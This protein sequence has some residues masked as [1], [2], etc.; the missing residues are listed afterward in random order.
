MTLSFLSIHPGFVKSYFEF[1]VFASAL[2]KNLAKVNVVNIRD[3]SDDKHS[4]VDAAP[5]GGGDG[6]VL[7]AD[8]LSSALN[9]CPKGTVIYTGPSGKPFTQAD[10]S[11]LSKVYLSGTP[12]NFVCGR[13]GGVDQRFL[14]KYVDETYCV[15]DAVVSGGELPS[16]MICDA[17]LRL[18]PG[19]LG[20]TDSYKQDSFSSDFN[21]G[22]EAPSYTKPRTFEG[23]GVPQVL[24][25]GNHAL[26][27]AWR[28]EQSLKNT[29]ELRPD[30]YANKK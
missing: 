17:L 16:L 22:L 19:V 21:G 10:A 9:S 23:M 5:Y 6:M 18:V 29:A 3:F 7:R 11:K 20:N 12:I 25:S 15:A 4:S 13:F 2:K 24:L 14:D 1:G 30:I 27:E 8:V 26:I 28:R